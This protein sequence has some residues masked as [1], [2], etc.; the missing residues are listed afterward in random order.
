MSSDAE[1]VRSDPFFGPVRRRHPDVDIVLLPAAD[2]ADIDAESAGG[3]VAPLLA[4]ATAAA[5][6]LQAELEG[7]W[8]DVLASTPVET[9]TR[10]TST[11]HSPR[12]IVTGAHPEV[13]AVE[14]A[15][16][17][18]QLQRRLEADGWHVLAPDT[19]MPRILASRR[20]VEGSPASAS[21]PDDEL[22]VVHVPRSGR[23]AAEWTRGP[24]RVAAA[25]ATSAD[26]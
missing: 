1:I 11:R 12:V 3:D 22:V 5:E 16:A 25:E 17:L 14:A 10:W 7:L 19:G 26:E 4:D 6:D 23:L 20:A 21:R 8:R 15:Q 2:A 18:A 13:G 9:S 24:W